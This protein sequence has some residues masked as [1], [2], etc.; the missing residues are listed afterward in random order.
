MLYNDWWFMLNHS[1]SPIYYKPLYLQWFIYILLLVAIYIYIIHCITKACPTFLPT[2]ELIQVNV[3]EAI[4]VLEI[5]AT[6][7]REWCPSSGVI[8]NGWGN[9]EKIWQ[10]HEHPLHVSANTMRKY[11]K[12]WKINEICSGC[13]LIFH[14]GPFVVTICWKIHT[15]YDIL[16]EN[17]SLE[18]TTNRY[19]VF[20]FQQGILDMFGDVMDLFLG[21]FLL[22]YGIFCG[23]VGWI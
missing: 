14:S 10:I 8:K 12:L 6:L 22:N 16:W 13:S 17:M 11:G 15:N 7:R 3:L 4:Q 1:Q 5:S 2:R 9:D 20:F 19:F 21:W 18:W 23:C